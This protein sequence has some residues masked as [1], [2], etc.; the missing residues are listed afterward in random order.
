M[1]K[2]R[3]LF[4]R[5]AQSKS[6]VT[7]AGCS[8]NEMYHAAWIN[9]LLSEVTYHARIYSILSWAYFFFFTLF[10]SPVF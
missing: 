7:F 4:D 8:F 6:E 5:A 9:Y 1:E 10:D 2:E 3:L